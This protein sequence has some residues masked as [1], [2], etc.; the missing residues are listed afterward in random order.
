[1]YNF[2]G[3]VSADNG[4]FLTKSAFYNDKLYISR[5]GV[6]VEN[7]CTKVPKST[8]LYPYSMYNFCGAVIAKKRVFNE[9]PHFAIK[10]CTFLGSG[11]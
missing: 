7:V 11:G 10:N 6:R 5:S 9:N 4:G 8:L 1:M 3:A 2:C